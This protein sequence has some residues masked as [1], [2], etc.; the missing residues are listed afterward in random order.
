[1]ATETRQADEGSRREACEEVEE[2]GEV[3]LSDLTVEK[4]TGVV[5][6]VTLFLAGAY[7]VLCAAMW[8]IFE[9]GRVMTLTG[10]YGLLIPAGLLA[11]PMLALKWALSMRK[12]GAKK[13]AKKSKKGAK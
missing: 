6:G 13:A 5:A 12:K 1:M 10:W 7:A 8:L 4:V 3:K 2:G 9:S 11:A